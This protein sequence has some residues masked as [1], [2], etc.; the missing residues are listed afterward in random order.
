MLLFGQN[1][2]S[3]VILSKYPNKSHNFPIYIFYDVIAL[4]H[5]GAKMVSE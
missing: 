2:L 4:E 3:D 1:G 5:Y